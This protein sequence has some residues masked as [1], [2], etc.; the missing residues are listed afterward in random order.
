MSFDSDIA[1]LG[2]GVAP[3]V[4]ANHLLI[5]GKTVLL[6]NPDLDFFLE[7]SELPLNPLLQTKVQ[8]QDLRQN[9]AENA[10]KEL[11]PDFPGAVELWSA[12]SDKNVTEKGG[13]HDLLAP[14]VHQRGRLWISSSTRQDK[15]W[16]WGNLEDL[17]VE[18]SD[19]SLNPQILDGL[20]AVRKFP[21]FSASA[22]NFRGLLV[23]KLSDV[24]TVRY[25]NGLLEFVR[26]RLP[27]ER[28]VCEASQIERMP[29]GIR[30]HARGGL[31]TAQLKDGMLVFWTPRL[32]S[33]LMGQAKKADVQPHFPRGIRFWEQWSLN[34]REP[35]DPGVVGL[36]DDMAV[37]SDFEGFPGT[38]G[39]SQ[40]A[41]LRAGPSMSLDE[42]NLPRGGLTSASTD[43]F[44]SLF[45]LC[46]SFLKW[47]R[48]SVRSLKVRAIFDWDQTEAWTLSQSGP[49][50]QIVPR[51]DG[52]LVDVVQT[53]RSACT[54]LL[55]GDIK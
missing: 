33:W 51:C 45:N 3:L 43:S 23:P 29:E 35:L 15:M 46:H 31:Q 9:L 17:Y 49:F 42:L 37:W 34:S 36:V 32:T 20:S 2:T 55:K 12:Q 41:V 30:F 8:I 6:L 22:A 52:P 50:I 18:A 38:A 7:D 1:L 26:E 27:P 10:L 14:H 47:D 40:L 4:A 21:G 25:R 13:F 54:R 28:V 11:R 39:S 44:N 19:A 48:F 24:D 53:A 16:S 5:Q